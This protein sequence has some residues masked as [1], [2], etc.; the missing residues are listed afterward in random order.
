M[1]LTRSRAFAIGSALYVAFFVCVRTKNFVQVGYWFLV[2]RGDAVDS[3]YSALSLPGGVIAALVTGLLGFGVHDYPAYLDRSL[4]LLLN[5]VAWGGAFA[6]LD[7]F[8]Q[9]VARGT[10]NPSYLDSSVNPRDSR[11]S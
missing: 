7:L 4:G 9:R 8:R 10:P 2:V 11:R 3:L 1:Q 6:L 5:I